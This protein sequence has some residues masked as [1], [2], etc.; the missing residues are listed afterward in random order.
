MTL[1]QYEKNIRQWA[2]DRGLI[3]GTNLE[4]QALK[5]GEEHGE[6]DKAI[7]KDDYINIVDGIGDMMVVLI[8]MCAKLDISILEALEYAWNQIKDRKGK[9]INGTFVKE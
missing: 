7:L 6:L 1:D 4:K 9:M 8:N 3:E 2:D 5:L